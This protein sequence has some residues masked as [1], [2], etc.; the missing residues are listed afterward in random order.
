[1]VNGKCSVC[2]RRI[3]NKDKRLTKTCGGKCS[4]EWAYRKRRDSW[5]KYKK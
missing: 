1:M 3:V 4:L 5:K 2:G